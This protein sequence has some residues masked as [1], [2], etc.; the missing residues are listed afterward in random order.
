MRGRECGIHR[1]TNVEIQEFRVHFTK[2]SIFYPRTDHWVELSC[3]ILKVREGGRAILQ[4]G[5]KNM[6][7]WHSWVCYNDRI[8]AS[9]MTFMFLTFF[10]KDELLFIYRYLH[11]IYMTK[12]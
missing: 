11:A 7:P 6:I 9:V 5:D 4:C 3:V 10:L 8:Q 12:P 2:D 1:H